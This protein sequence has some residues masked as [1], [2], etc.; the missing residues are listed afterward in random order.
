MSKLCFTGEGHDNAA[1]GI[2]VL[3]L[4]SQ[5]DTETVVCPLLPKPL[6][7]PKSEE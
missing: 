1:A 7:F 5:T 4:P 6:D 2:F 3:L